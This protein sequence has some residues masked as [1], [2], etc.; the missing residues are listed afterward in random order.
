LLLLWHVPRAARAWGRRGG[1]GGSTAVTLV[2][3]DAVRSPG[4][5]SVMPDGSVA[6]AVSVTVAP[7]RVGSVPVTM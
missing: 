5:G 1:G 4:V 2:V 7:S 6:V 3:A